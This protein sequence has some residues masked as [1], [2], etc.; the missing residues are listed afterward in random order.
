LPYQGEKDFFPR[1]HRVRMRQLGE[2]G[3]LA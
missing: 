3:F 1:W 2:K